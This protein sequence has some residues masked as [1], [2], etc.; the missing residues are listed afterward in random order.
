MYKYLIM[1][2]LQ[3]Q[4]LIK[5]LEI[6]TVSQIN[7][8]DFNVNGNIEMDIVGSSIQ[9]TFIS[10]DNYLKSKTVNLET[11]KNILIEWVNFIINVFG[12]TDSFYLDAYLVNIKCKELDLDWDFGIKGE[13]NINRNEEERREEFNKIISLVQG[14][15]YKK[16][17]WIKDV[18]MDFHHA[19]RYP[20][21]TGQYC[22]R[23]IET[24]RRAYYENPSILDDTKRRDEGWENLCKK[25]GYVREDFTQIEYYG[26]PNR[27]GYYPK[28]E[29][30]EREHIMNFTRQ[31]I[32]CFTR[33]C[34][35]I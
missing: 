23:A 26:I 33:K 3:P 6:H 18:F 11:L 24:I 35:K 13:Y 25:L 10:K 31:L 22:F 32:D 1:G 29:Y 8:L 7:H 30:K 17:S 2:V 4:N 28:I 27:H 20:S 5:R 12:Y 9:L 16:F 34:I 15:D 21:Q 14:K 19:I